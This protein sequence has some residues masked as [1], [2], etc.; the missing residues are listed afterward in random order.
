MIA[1]LSEE[2]KS[3]MQAEVISQLKSPV[4]IPQMLELEPE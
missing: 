4:I 3:A 1:K 2:E